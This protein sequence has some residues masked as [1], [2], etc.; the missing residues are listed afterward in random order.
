MKQ[1]DPML[2]KPRR[3]VARQGAAV[4]LVSIYLRS[5]GEGLWVS[6]R[7]R[8][9]AGSWVSG[10]VGRR[11]GGGPTVP[12]HGCFPLHSDLLE[13]RVVDEV[14]AEET[15]DVAAP[16]VNTCPPNAVRNKSALSTFPLEERTEHVTHIDRVQL[17]VLGA[18]YERALHAQ[19]GPGDLEPAVALDAALGGG[20]GRV[21]SDTGSAGV[22]GPG[23]LDPLL[24]EI[25]DVVCRQVA[26]ETLFLFLF[27]LLVSFRGGGIGFLG[28][29]VILT[30][31]VGCRAGDGRGP[32]VLDGLR[33]C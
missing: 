20:S 31:A 27:L 23:S 25:L 2:R 4:V 17:R 15:V 28:R 13:C 24:E 18:V 10:G 12:F 6:V 14:V 9:R 33:R 22:V 11:G 32:V 30:A 16:R 3:P 29:I 19:E 5:S 1:V 7:R 8:L 21:K 26:L